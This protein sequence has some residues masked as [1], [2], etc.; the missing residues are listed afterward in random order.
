M[1]IPAV[2]PT[3][4]A[5]V[6]AAALGGGAGC[7]YDRLRVDGD[8][9]HFG[10]GGLDDDHLL[11]GG[12]GLRHHFLLFRGLQVSH[13]L[14]L[15]TQ[16]LDRF[17]DGGLVGGVG[18]AE[19]LRPVRLLRQHLDDLRKRRE[20]DVAGGE[21]GLLR[22]VLQGA[23]LQ[24]G[25]AGEPAGELLQG[26]HVDRRLQDLGHQRVGIER[27]WRRQGV[28]GRARRRLAG[29]GGCRLPRVHCARDDERS[30]HRQHEC[31]CG[32]ASRVPLEVHLLCTQRPEPAGLHRGSQL[33]PA[34]PAFG[35]RQ[36]QARPPQ[37]MSPK[38][39]SPTS[40]PAAPSGRG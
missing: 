26:R 27:D 32:D 33:P 15:A 28:N 20:R 5:P 16:A 9:D 31:P 24:A 21:P 22:G 36:H 4:A 39:R 13:R 2:K 40:P 6:T 17:V 11:P 18:L 38:R 23:A 30:Q 29:R 7:T 3:T 14:R 1:M 37:N 12:R 19:L 35:T 25:L 8:V 10:V 34:I